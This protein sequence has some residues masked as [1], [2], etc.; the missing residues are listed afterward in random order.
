MLTLDEA[1]EKLEKE[2]LYVIDYNIESCRHWEL[3]IYN[4]QEEFKVIEEYSGETI[5]EILEKCFK[6][7]VKD[8]EIYKS[9]FHYNYGITYTNIR[10]AEKEDNREIITTE[11]DV[12]E[13]KIENINHFL[14]LLDNVYETMVD[15]Y[16][17]EH[18][19]KVEQYL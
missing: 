6:E 5:S 17:F 1:M 12:Y 13:T 16:E 18:F 4:N 2:K 11:L 14:T 19:D 15:C 9:Y 8:F 10:P 7:K 3:I